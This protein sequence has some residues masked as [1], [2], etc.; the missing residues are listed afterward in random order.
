MAWLVWAGPLAVC[1][2]IVA[3]VALV[4]LGRGLFLLTALLT[5]TCRW[6]LVH[7]GY[8]FGS[9]TVK[10][11]DVA[12]AAM[13][14]FIAGYLAYQARPD[15]KGEE[16]T[17][18][19]AGILGLPIATYALLQFLVPPAPPQTDLAAC[20]N[21][22]TAG[23]AYLSRTEVNGL[24][25]RS[26]PGTTYAAQ[27]RFGA[28]CMIGVDGYCVGEPVTD[29]LV[30]L[31]D[32]RWLRLRHSHQYIASGRVF[33]LSPEADLGE[34]PESDCPL[35]LDD[36]ALSGPPRLRLLR[37]DRIRI[38]A[39]VDR[40]EL[41]GFSLFY[42]ENRELGDDQVIEQLGITPKLTDNNG[43]V[44]AELNLASV[45]DTSP[46]AQQVIVG[47]IPCLAPIVPSH[48]GDAYRSIDLE[49]GAI[50]RFNAPSFSEPDA[51]ERMRQAGCRLDP[52]MNNDDFMA[53]ATR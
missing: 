11:L 31:P 50:K 24:N 3:T 36:P 2:L 41:V 26:G 40:T 49:S 44:S 37:G 52:N 5:L 33:A 23:A 30:P 47:I 4:L 43:Q 29:L 19:I 14:L 45:R 12:L 42:V 53:A 35:R 18:L 10:L 48:R 15:A 46:K 9:S 16:R 7:W 32:V 8:V 22:P 13:I 1:I 25:A 39:N 6:A 28:D 51:H 21:A 27:R 34:A 20:D 17:T 38:T